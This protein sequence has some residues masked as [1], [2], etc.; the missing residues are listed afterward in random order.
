M[1]ET[2]A[3]APVA[4][5]DGDEIRDLRERQNAVLG[6]GGQIWHVICAL[7]ELGVA[8]LLADG[9]ADVVKLAAATDSNPDALRRVLRCAAAVG[10]FTEQEDG[11]FGLSPLAEGLVT[12][13]VGGLRPMIRF[14]A[15]EIARRPYEQILYS[16][17]TGKPAFDH[18]Y[19]MPFHQ[20]VERNPELAGFYSGFLAHFSR[21]L[22]DRFAGRL[23]LGRFSR[24]ADIGAGTGYFLARMLEIQPSATGVLFDAASVCAQ[25]PEVL[26]E[27]GVSERATV[28]SGDLFTDDLPSGCDLFTL[29][30]VLH[31]YQDEE[32]V[33]LLSRIRA[34]LDR[35][36][37]RVIAIDQVLPPLNT[38]DHSKAI[39]IDTLVL[40]GGKERN[41]AE[42][43]SLLAAS[44]FALSNV[45]E[46]HGWTFLE[47]QPLP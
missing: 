42:W 2:P 15:M 4:L 39:D 30:S 22:A 29:K 35:Q 10:I 9:P 43:R 8:D 27:H 13:R 40:Y 11:G 44:G 18:V 16:I 34:A 24:I 41:M 46:P 32:A 17:R 37:G 25:A 6:S 45:G 38:W 7:A 12:G 26:S 33:A 14:H 28:I 5:V 47:F 36:C 31:R 23:G 21:R 1:G 20:Y 3:S 19:G